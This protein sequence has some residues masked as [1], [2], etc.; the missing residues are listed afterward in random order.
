MDIIRA[1]GLMTALKN[2][3]VDQ[4]I[5]AQED[6]PTLDV[7][8][9]VAMTC[10]RCDLARTRKTVV[11]GEGDPGADIVFIGEAPGDKTKASYFSRYLF[12]DRRSSISISLFSLSIEVTSEFR[13]TS[14]LKRFLNKPGVATRSDSSFF[15][16]SPTK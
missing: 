11:F 8:K 1:K 2:M 6:R 14:I 5:S 13:R 15:I 4:Y 12:R 3:G 16:T 10:T 9:A 7:L